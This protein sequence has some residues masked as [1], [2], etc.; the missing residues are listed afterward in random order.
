[1]QRPNPFRLE[2]FSLN[3]R[4]RDIAVGDIHGCF[5]EIATRLT[6]IG[7]DKSVDRL[8]C[9]G[10]LID[11]GSQSDQVLEWLDEPW[12]HSIMG[13]HEQMAW[14][15]VKGIP[16]DRR[17]HQ[18][19]GGEWL[20]LLPVDEQMAIAERL[21]AL[22]LVIEVETPNG[23]VGLVHADSYFDDWFEL[24]S[25]DW[26]QL[27]DDA[28]FVRCCLWSPLRFK[29]QYRRVVKNV[30]VVIHGHVTVPGVTVLGNTFYIDTGGWLPEG[31]FTLLNLHTL[32]P[33]LPRALP[34][35]S[36]G[37]KA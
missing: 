31:H 15:S 7:F 18:M 12:L 23:I 19:N 25:I 29:R 11:R 4:G 36:A 32:M 2:S 5:Q 37:G 35:G 28:P 34:D 26:T 17:F 6:Q 13:N 22:P 1:M 21:S 14:R 33:E 9:V 3:R 10:D 8:F 30:R 24:R 20:E 27:H 16:F